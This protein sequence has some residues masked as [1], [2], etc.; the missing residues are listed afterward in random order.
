MGKGLMGGDNKERPRSAVN[1][2]KK[3]KEM[4]GCPF[5][6]QKARQMQ[7]AWWPDQ[8]NLRVLGSPSGPMVKHQEAYAKAFAT[9]DMEAVKKDL[10]TLMTTSQSWYI[11]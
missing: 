1:D 8:L 5:H 4:S 6:T 9:L 3:I 7:A 2:I 11:P 10:S